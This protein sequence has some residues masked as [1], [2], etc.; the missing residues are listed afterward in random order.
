[1][2]N[3]FKQKLNAIKGSNPMPRVK[4]DPET[5]IEINLLLQR[6]YKCSIDFKLDY[7]I[8]WM[9]G[10]E[11]Y[12][13]DKEGR[14]NSK[15][16][17]DHLARGHVVEVELF[18]HFNRELTFPHPCVVLY[19]GSYNQNSGWML[20][21]PISTSRFNDGSD[22]TVDVTVADG[23]KHDCGVCIDS[24]QVIDKRRVLF[25]H[26]LPNKN[27]SKV[28]PTKLDEID[29]CITKNYL[30]EKFKKQCDIE[31]DLSDEKL[32]HDATKAQLE[33]LKEKYAE[34]EEKFEKSLEKSL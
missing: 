31:R 19:D 14:T 16:F 15:W 21:A 5:L 22:F 34:L 27:K 25:Q 18:G 4:T 11:K 30:P 33:A 12:V 13:Q 20:V 24:I 9:N 29:I 2:N 28:S 10:L 8:K 7:G 1:M 6:L 26:E 23:L 17:N 32:S 3:N